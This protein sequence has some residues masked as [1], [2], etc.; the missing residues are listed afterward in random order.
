MHSVLFLNSNDLVKLLST[1]CSSRP[2]RTHSL[3]PS[4][5]SQLDSSI[6]IAFITNYRV[7]SSDAEAYW[8]RESCI[9]Y[10]RRWRGRCRKEMVRRRWADV[11]PCI[12]IVT[13]AYPQHP[14]CRQPFP[15]AMQWH[16][17][18]SSFTHAHKF[19]LFNNVSRAH[20]FSYYRLLDV[21]YM[22]VMIYFVWE[23]PLSLHRRL[24]LISSKGSF[25]CTFPQTGQ[26]IP[27][28]LMD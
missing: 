2:I 4:T 11:S 18:T 7:V 22:V 9:K 3:V 14:I 21:K 24:F 26:H 8:Q 10:R 17:P 20:L 23:N 15:Q 12:Q 16:C 27:Q 1:A 19:V 6:L 13:T 5:W 28:P 25:I